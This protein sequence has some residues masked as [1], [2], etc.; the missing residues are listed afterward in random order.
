MEPQYTLRLLGLECLQAQELDGDETYLTLNDQR[1]WAAAPDKMLGTPNQPIHVSRYDFAAGRK[2]TV[3]GWVS[4]DAF[5]P[6][7]FIFTGLRGQ[8][9]LRLWDAD[10]L[11]SDDLLGE[12][13]IS[14]RDGAHGQIAVMFAR[15]G[16]QYRLSYAVDVDIEARS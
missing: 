8:T 16:A 15:D 6:K 5:Q 14:A 13:P 10:I 1:I 11:T 7:R 9:L 3:D 4:I 12:T 2:L